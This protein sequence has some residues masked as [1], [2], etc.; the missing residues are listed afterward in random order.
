MHGCLTT[1]LTISVLLP[2]ADAA[3][4]SSRLPSTDSALV[5]Y[6][7]MVAIER[8]SGTIADVAQSPTTTWWKFTAPE[9]TVPER[10]AALRKHLMLAVRG[11]DSVA[12]DSTYSFVR[13]SRVQVSGD[14]LRFWLGIGS[15]FRCPNAWYGNSGSYQVQAIRSDTTWMLPPRIVSSTYSHSRDCP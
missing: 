5:S 1:C 6:A 15:A 12:T 9:S 3:A 7:G 8:L 10:W 4:Q 2:H 13:V 11:R 14:T